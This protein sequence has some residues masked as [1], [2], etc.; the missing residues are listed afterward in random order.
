ML[1]RNFTPTL[2]LALL[3]TFITGDEPR[4]QFAIS[5]TAEQIFRAQFQQA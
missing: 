4:I 1:P 3:S 2:Q 5:F